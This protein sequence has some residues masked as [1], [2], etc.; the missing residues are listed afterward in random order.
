[1]IARRVHTLSLFLSLGAAVAVAC[2]GPN[3]GYIN[4]VDDESGGSGNSGATGGSGNGEAGESS[5][6]GD[7]AGGDGDVPVLPTP[8]E[9]VSV[10]PSGDELAEPAGSIEIEFSEGLDPE[11]VTLESI[12]LLDGEV[13]VSGTLE[14]SGVTA[15]FTPDVRLDLLGAY[16]VSVSTDITDI[17][18]TAME[19]P[20]ETD[21]QVRDGVWGEEMVVENATGT[22][23]P[24]LVSPVI[25]GYGNALVVWGQA[26]PDDPTGLTSVWGRFYRPGEGWGDAFEIDQTDGGCDNLSVAMNADG[27][28]VVAWNQTV[29]GAYGVAARR[30]IAGAWEDFAVRVDALDTA[31]NAFIVTTA[32]SPTGEAHVFWNYNDGTDA[33]LKTTHAAPEADW[34]QPE[35]IGFNDRVAQPGVAFD[36]DG[37]GFAFFVTDSD[38]TGVKASLYAIRYIASSEA[39]GSGQSIVDS[40]EASFQEVSVVADDDGGAYALFERYDDQA[41]TWDVMSTTFTKAAGFSDAI[42]IDIL[43]S[44]PSSIP[45]L[46]SNGR[47]RVASWSQSASLTENAYSALGDGGAYA[48]QELRSDGD[49]DGEYGDVVAGV[50]RRGNA[51]LLFAQQSPEMSDDILFSRFAAGEWTEAM[52]VNSELAQYQDARVAVAANGMAVAVWSIGIR[53]VANSILVSVFE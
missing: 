23:H 34:S 32:V 35:P 15:V 31:V 12:Q 44:G 43:D 5:Q 26:A 20:Y 25:D 51:L 39:W 4:I 48:E 50:D 30:Y 17:G 52:K 16:T 47:V 14:Y 18:G 1:M 10:T 22:L 19:D 37:N 40:S 27:D 3:D 6:G 21:V 49:F 11:T 9:V 38:S 33:Y 29:E 41:L 36:P 28:A 2:G 8:P 42:A 13:A 24:Q 45:R 53:Q 7:G 46:S